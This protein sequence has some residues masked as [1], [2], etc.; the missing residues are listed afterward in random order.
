MIPL[1]RPR[2]EDLPALESDVLRECRK[3]L[4]EQEDVRVWRNNTGALRDANGRTVTYGLAKGSSDLIGIVRVTVPYGHPG[5]ERH[6]AIARYIARFLA[7]ELKQPGK[8]P[9]EDQE[10]FLEVVRASGGVAF[11][12]DSLD[13][14]ISM[15][16]KARRWEV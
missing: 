4:A 9:T 5:S 12:A 15:I 10:R 7:I 1:K 11:W 2:R 8:K 13:T 6:P 16:E 14:V 3:W